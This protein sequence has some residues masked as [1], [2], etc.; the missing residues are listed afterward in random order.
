MEVLETKL[1]SI[2]VQCELDTFVNVEKIKSWMFDTKLIPESKTND[3]FFVLTILGGLLNKYH[4]KN[5]CLI[6]DLFNT[7]LELSQ[8]IPVMALN[9]KSLI[10]AFEDP[11]EKNAQVIL[12][13]EEFN[14][15][16]TA[17]VSLYEDA[18][19]CMRNKDFT[20]AATIFD[21][22]FTALLDDRT[23]YREIYRIFCNA[24]L[25]YL[26]S[27]NATLG[28][29]CVSIAKEIN[30]HYKFAEFQLKQIQDGKLAPFIEYGYLLKIKDRIAKFQNELTYEKVQKWPKA[31]ILKKLSKLGVKIN[32][33]Q[34]VEVARTVHS[35]DDLAKKLFYPQ[36]QELGNDEDFISMAAS[37]LWNI[38]CPDEP[39]ISNLNKVISNTAKFV[40]KHST[41]QNV[42]DERIISQ[43]AS[44][45]QKFEKFIYLGKKGFLKHWAKTY[46]FRTAARDEL[47][48]ILKN[49][50]LIPELENRVLDLVDYLQAQLPDEYWKIVNIAVLVFKS[51]QA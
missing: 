24:G 26:L 9:N 21:E 37:A 13:L 51:N 1:S 42:L 7:I 35:S 39:E 23:T 20:V 19:K 46:E 3:K 22:V 40:S 27:G 15:P 38:Y 31:R 32:K 17:W 10:N 18:M 43:Y 6:N 49:M 33:D 36:N 8:R 28:T 2:L 41:S 47:I 16:P 4:L 30:P 12:Y 29:K 34:F 11:S 5:T 14:F 44:H 48:Q 45:L 50:V 25:S